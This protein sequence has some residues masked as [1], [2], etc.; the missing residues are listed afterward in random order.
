[1]TEPRAGASAGLLVSLRRL[2][3]TTIELGRVRLELLGTEVER[4]KLSILSALLWAALG[5]ASVALGLVLVSG[6]IVLLFWDS[7]RLSAIA[8]LAVVYFVL[9]AFA[10][11][12]AVSRI[13]T[14][15]G[16]FALSSAELARDQAALAPGAAGATE[17]P[18]R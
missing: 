10:I 2:A 11:R 7:Y 17:T 16:A 9:G 6:F 1:M 18:P 15:G 14:P 8:R 5:C 3:A 4:Q 13:Q 12:Y